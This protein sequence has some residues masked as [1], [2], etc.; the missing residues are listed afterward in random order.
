MQALPWRV[1]SSEQPTN[2]ASWEATVRGTRAICKILA[3]L[4]SAHGDELS[5]GGWDAA[6][7]R[8]RWAVAVR[9]PCMLLRA[10]SVTMSCA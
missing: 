7:Q 6:V 1:T 3:A 5:G 8:V 9:N 4:I 10:A 2:L